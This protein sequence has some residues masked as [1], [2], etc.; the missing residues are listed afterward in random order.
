MGRPQFPRHQARQIHPLNVPVDR[1]RPGK[2]CILITP[3][4]IFPFSF[5][6]TAYWNNRVVQSEAIRTVSSYS[7]V[8]S[9]QLRVNSNKLR[10]TVLLTHPMT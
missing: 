4:K 1:D 8:N 7:R 5:P 3:V 9:A 6:G 10:F 2:D